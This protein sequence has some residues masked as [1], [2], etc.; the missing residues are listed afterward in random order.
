VSDIN[1]WD[2]FFLR[3][4]KQISTASL[5]PSTKTGSIIVDKNNRVVSMG[6]NGFAKGVK[7][8]PERYNNRE[9]KYKLIV[10]TEVNSIIFAKQD[11]TNCTLYTWPF[12]S[13]SRCAGIVIQAGIKRCVAPPLP[14]HLKERW[15]EDTALAELQFKEAGVQ[16]DFIELSGS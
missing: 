13:C 7:D 5:D 4:A 10:H 3:M 1:K 11:L 16:L 14:T 12:C 15:A 6:Y 9:L 8:L 2:I